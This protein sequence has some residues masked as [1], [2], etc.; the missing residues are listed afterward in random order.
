MLAWLDM[1]RRAVDRASLVAC[2]T[3]GLSCASA[4]TFGETGFALSLYDV[5][6]LSA[7]SNTTPE[8]RVGLGPELNAPRS[9]GAG[10]DET[11]GVPALSSSASRV[12]MVELPPDAM[13]PG[14]YKRPHHGLGYRWGAAESWLRDHGVD[15][16][17]C[18]LPMVRM[19]TKIGPGASSALWLYGRCS[20]R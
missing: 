3:V 9:L 20:F 18:Y 2:A 15:A 6:P 12:S 4:P 17:T 19:H 14:A 16:Q 5:P 13:A 10:P 7:P 11:R 1:A 8:R